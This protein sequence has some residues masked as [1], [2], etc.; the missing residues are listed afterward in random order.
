MRARLKGVAVVAWVA[1][2]APGWGADVPGDPRHAECGAT[3]S[4]REE[5]QSASWYEKS[6]ALRQARGCRRLA[7]W[8][9]GDV[10]RLLENDEDYLVREDAAVT[11]GEIGGPDDATIRA[12]IE[13]S[14]GPGDRVGF[15]AATV[16][17]RKFGVAAVGELRAALRAGG[18]EGEDRPAAYDNAL[19]ALTMMGKAYGKEAVTPALV[20]ALKGNDSEAEGAAQVLWRLGPPMAAAPNLIA[21]LSEG[22]ESRVRW[23]A[24]EALGRM[25]VVPEA[26]PNLTAALED[27]WAATRRAAAEA[28]G[29][30]GAAARTAIPFLERMA[31]DKD[32]SVAGA[33]KEAVK[34]IEMASETK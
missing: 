1:V 11:L 17:A 19:T 25:G 29:S 20:E 14:G 9:L 5:L 23:A 18:W 32:E 13:A 3:G 28:L 26:V 30:M 27:G 21:C 4:L 22:R 6:M 15:V 34:K 12:L 8:A 2:A 10:A 31:L 16:I 24:A 33:A 7:A